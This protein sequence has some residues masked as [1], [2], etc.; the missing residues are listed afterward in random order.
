MCIENNSCRY[1]SRAVPIPFAFDAPRITPDFLGT[2]L[3]EA[4]AAQ[5]QVLQVGKSL[6][7]TDSSSLQSMCDSVSDVL[8]GVT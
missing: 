4:P 2:L 7:D 6:V 8:R 3:E 1:L 5:P